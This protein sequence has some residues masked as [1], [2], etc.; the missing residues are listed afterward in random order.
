MS[1]LLLDC[2]PSLTAGTAFRARERVVR[3]FVDY[4]N[5]G[6]QHDSS[7][8][9]LKRWQVQHDGGASTEDIAR[10]EVAITIGILSNTFPSA[11]WILFNTYSRPDLLAT[12]RE[13]VSKHA[14]CIEPG[15]RIHTVNL[16]LIRDACP[17]LLSVFQEVLRVHSNGPVTRF[18]YQ[19]MMLDDQFLLKEGAIL[20]MPTPVLLQEIPK[21][22]ADA[23]VFD[24]L[25]F[26][27]DTQKERQREKPRSTS[28][29]PF[30]ASPFLCP[31]RHFATGEVLALA[32]MMM[33][34]YDVEPTAGKWWTPKLKSS[35]VAASVTPPGEPYPVNISERQEYG[36]T[37]WNFT[38]AEGK[39]VF[40][41][42]TG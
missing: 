29:I 7:E 9:A 4:Y 22:G 12:I 30:G 18:V 40:S 20:Q 27:P 16:G 11:F 28:F 3:A 37:S 15:T 32:A 31:G 6:G 10:N 5:A 8:L 13:E 25:R 14:L 19:D 33:L 42:V 1:V 24:G 38:V 36:G 21:W 35:A 39:G 41:L 34:R 26:D 17:K 23:S 2:W